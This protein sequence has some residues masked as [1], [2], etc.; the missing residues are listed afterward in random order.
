MYHKVFTLLT[1]IM[2]ITLVSKAQVTI[3]IQPGPDE[4]QDV[5]LNSVNFTASP[6][7]QSL[8]ASAWTYWGS[9]GYGRSFL[10]FDLPEIPPSATNFSASLQLYHDPSAVHLGHYGNNAAYLERVIEDWNPAQMNWANQPQVSDKNAVLLMESEKPEQDYILDV[11]ALIADCYQYPEENF[12]LRLKLIQEALYASLVFA[13]G[14]HPDA[15]IRPKLVITYD[16]CNQLLPDYFTYESIGLACQFEYA[17]SNYSFIE[18]DF[19]N[20]YGAHIQN[21][22]YYFPEPGTYEVSLT[23]VNECDSIT[24]VQT[25]TVCELFVADF[26]YIIEDNNVFFTNLSPEGLNYYWDFGNGFFSWLEH[27]EFQFDTLGN[28]DV[29]LHVTNAC[30]T[31]TVCKALFIDKLGLDEEPQN[32]SLK[33]FPVPAQN[34]VSIQT[35][36]ESINEVKIY[37][38]RGVMVLHERLQA[39]QREKHIEVGHLPRAAYFLHIETNHGMRVE[40][41]ILQ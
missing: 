16:T 13:S 21:P 5:Y 17:E 27:P 14:D 28:F 12:G 22:L 2:L 3:E 25:V 35:K 34:T 39:M 11:T 9:E 6:H 20:G 4:N 37:D 29:C 18:W 41:I 8:I 1:A 15:S 10:R 36:D 23:V 26:S 30:T 24:I 40:K 38:M 7:V 32:E 31:V 19:G 33:V